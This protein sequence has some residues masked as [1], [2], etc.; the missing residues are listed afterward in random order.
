MSDVKKLIIEL[1][2]SKE[3]V[4]SKELLKKTKQKYFD[5]RIREL[6]DE[7]GYD[8]IN[9]FVNGEPHYKLNSSKRNPLKERTYLSKKQKDEL[10]IKNKDFCPLCGNQ[11]SDIRK[12]SYDHRI[13]LI[14][15]GQG[16]IENFQI[17]CHE[18]NNQKRSQCRHCD[19]DC[20]ICFL[21]FPETANPVIL[22]QIDKETHDKISILSK[23]DKL[24][25]NEFILKIIKK[26]I[27]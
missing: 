17:I 5:R 26:Y 6:K 18:C 4:S 1:L 25:Q 9:K 21:A 11:F 27:K 19:L 2:Q 22:L 14:K 16:T 7:E 3:W 12:M 20:N 8:I 24:T 13:P 15:G 23:K 10:R